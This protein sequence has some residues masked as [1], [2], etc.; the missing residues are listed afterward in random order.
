MSGNCASRQSC[1]KSPWDWDFASA[2][3]GRAHCT[4]QLSWGR[5]R[6]YHTRVWQRFCFNYDEREEVLGEGGSKKL[7]TEFKQ[8]CLSTPEKRISIDAADAAGDELMQSELIVQVHVN[9]NKGNIACGIAVV[10]T[11]SGQESS[12]RSHLTHA[13]PWIMHG[14]GLWSKVQ[15][16]LYGKAALEVM[17][18][19]MLSAGEGTN[20]EEI[21]QF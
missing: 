18:T 21:W 20:L 5:S 3:A 19:C 13:P 17:Y 10:A 8:K 1:G 16:N 4:V 14:G 11:D 6:P 15:E 7:Q 9:G 2:F 12:P